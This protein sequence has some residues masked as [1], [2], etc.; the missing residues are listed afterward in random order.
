MTYASKYP[1]T[2]KD[3]P[4]TTEFIVLY[5]DTVSEHDYHGGSPSNREIVR[6]MTFDTEKLMKEYITSELQATQWRSAKSPNDFR[7][8]PYYPVTVSLKTEFNFK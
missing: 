4:E 6:V 8:V 3:I 7:I 5:N 1:S 2:L